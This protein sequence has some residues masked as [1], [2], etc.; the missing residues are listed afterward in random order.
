MSSEIFHCSRNKQFLPTN[1]MQNEPGFSP[2][3][4]SSFQ[5]FYL[6]LMA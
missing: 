4:Y 3:G 1:E 6:R 2:L 5:R